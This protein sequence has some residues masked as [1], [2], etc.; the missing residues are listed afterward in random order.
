MKTSLR[1]LGALAILQAFDVVATMYG[2]E[3]GYAYEA[4]PIV[5]TIVD[6]YGW[7]A[8]AAIKAAGVTFFGALIGLG[9][10]RRA[11]EFALWFLNAATVALT[12]IPHTI[13]FFRSAA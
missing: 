12:T 4:N 5:A 6:K 13:L 10:A 11:V 2:I 1:L 7:W 3:R 9:V 8:V